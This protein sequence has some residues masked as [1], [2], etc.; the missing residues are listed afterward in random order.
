MRKTEGEFMAA[1]STSTIDDMIAEARAN[2][3]RDSGGSSDSS[4]SGAG[5]AEPEGV[6]IRRHSS[7]HIQGQA[8]SG[9][10]VA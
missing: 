10:V 9:K 7:E 1:A 2:V 3:G 4:Q 6:P 5:S 8:K